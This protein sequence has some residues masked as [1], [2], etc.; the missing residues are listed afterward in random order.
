[1]YTHQCLVHL[2]PGTK[3]N[4]QY[5]IVSYYALATLLPTSLGLCH[6]WR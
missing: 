5:R 2:Q 6:R 3:L 1:M 4:K